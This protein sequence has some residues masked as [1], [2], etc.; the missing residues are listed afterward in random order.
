MIEIMLRG[1][2]QHFDVR[3]VRMDFSDSVSTAG[4]FAFSKVWN[5]FQLVGRTWKALGLKRDRCLYYPPASPNLVPIIRDLFFLILVRPFCKRLILHFHAGGVYRYAEAHPWLRPLMKLA[6]GRMDLGIIN[7]E[8]CPDDPGYFGA[9]NRKVVPYGLDVESDRRREHTSAS[10]KVLYVGIHTE[11][12]GLF[13][14]LETARLIKEKDVDFVMRTVGV[15]YTE[16]EKMR[17][18]ELC[19]SYDLEDVV[20]S[21]GRKTGDDLWEEYRNA[22]VLFFPTHYPWETMGIVQLEAMAHG[23]PVVAS[24]WQGPKDVVIEGVTG[25]LCLHDNPEAFADQL[26]LIAN[27]AELRMRMG[28]AGR[29]RYESMYTVECFMERVEDAFKTLA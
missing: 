19:K 13:T 4:K 17:F 5:L 11:E 23:L 20:I 6:Y 16:Q 14:L 10:F 26:E 15:W 1:V 3:F 21:V 2:Q 7:G 9:R 24:D 8:S 27:D 25:F 22:D 12:K 29:K 18:A 28:E